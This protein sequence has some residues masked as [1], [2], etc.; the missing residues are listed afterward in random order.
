M[1][2]RITCT[3]YTSEREQIGTPVVVVREAGTE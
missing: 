2:L 1:N 3:F